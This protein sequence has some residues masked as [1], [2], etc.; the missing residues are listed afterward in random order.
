M[1]TNSFICFLL[2]LFLSV[3]ASHAQYAG[4]FARMGFG[5]RGIAMGNALA[6]DTQSDTSPYYN[7]AF[8]PLGSSQKLEI[9]VAS[10]S[11]DRSLQF[12]QLSAPLQKKAGFALGVIHAS[13]SE[14]DGRDRSGFHTSTLSVDEYAG[15]LAFGL[16]FSDKIS[17]GISLQMFQTDL[18]EGLTPARSVGLDV[19]L[20]YQIR[21]TWSI[22]LVADD[23]LARYSWDS[24]DLGGSGRSVTDTFPRRIRLGVSTYQLKG[25]L[26]VHTEIESRFATVR[27][28]TRKTR[29]FGDS[30]A[31]TSE[32]G[33]LTDQEFRFRS[34]IEYK[35]LDGFSVRAGVEQLG[36][37]VLDSVRPS[38]GFMG[39]QK[40][41][42]LKIR[43]EYGF[44]YEARAAGKMHLVSLI[45]FL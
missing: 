38:L 8:S 39:E 24:S 13:V 18:F 31:E 32:E 6:A 3:S 4:S 7:P 1:K 22:G 43:A 5:A 15:F 14:I 11:F 25:K 16:K 29:I 12:L 27:F 37:E 36:S 2:F 41:G 30:P 42:E 20:V 28:E 33:T 40:V 44:A 35:P 45:L 19:G 34:G 23:L 10:L 17:G 21:P 26:S 9:S